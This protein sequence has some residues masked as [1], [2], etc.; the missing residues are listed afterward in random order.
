M[1][2]MVTVIVFLLVF[3]LVLIPAGGTVLALVIGSRQEKAR[4]QAERDSVRL[5]N[6]AFRGDAVTVKI[7]PDTMKY[8]TVVLGA[9]KRSYRLVA[10]NSEPGHRKTLVFTRS[11]GSTP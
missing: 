11:S 6:E 1:G 8:E 9:E 3:F 10:E 4:E 2:G 5:L 7:G